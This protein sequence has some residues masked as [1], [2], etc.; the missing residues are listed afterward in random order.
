MLV[1]VLFCFLVFV[2]VSTAYHSLKCVVD[3]VVVVVAVVVV[4]VVV[5]V[6]HVLC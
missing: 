4:V 6:V 1:C 3:V 5:V 2:Y